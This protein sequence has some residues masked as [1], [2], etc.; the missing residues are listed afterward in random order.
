MVSFL[1]RHRNLQSLTSSPSFF[2]RQFYYISIPARKNA[3]V[4]H[5]TLERWPVMI[6]SHG[7]GGSRNAY[8]HAAGSIASH[9]VI[10]I[11]PEHRDGS[12]PISFVRSVPQGQEKGEKFQVTKSKSRVGYNRVSHTP[13]PEV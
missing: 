12:A 5:P 4:L 10:V 7:L 3:P 2:P 13:S 9:G 11:C 1:F 6:F 8:S